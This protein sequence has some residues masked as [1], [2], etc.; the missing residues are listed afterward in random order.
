MCPRSFFLY[1]RSVCCT[2]APVLGIQEHQVLYPRSGFCALVP[3]F[4]GQGTSAKTTPLD[5]LR[6]PKPENSHCLRWVGTASGPFL[7]KTLFPLE[8]GLK[9][10]F[11]NLLKW[12]KKWSKMDFG[13]KSGS[14]C[15]KTHL[16]PTLN[17]LQDIDKNPF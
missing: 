6:T 3:I 10:V 7:E 15:V 4:W 1:R 14:Q 9:W 17:P 16:L 11:V 2:L 12:V 5:L 13:C 8:L